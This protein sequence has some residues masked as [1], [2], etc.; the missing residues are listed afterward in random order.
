MASPAFSAHLL[1][2]KDFPPRPARH[3]RHRTP[4]AYRWRSGPGTVTVAAQD[5]NMQ[6]ADLLM[7]VWPPRGKCWKVGMGRSSLHEFHWVD[8]SNSSSGT[9]RWG[10]EISS[11]CLQSTSVP[12]L[13]F[14][15]V[16]RIQLLPS[17]SPHRPS[18]SH[19]TCGVDWVSLSP[20]GRPRCQRGVSLDWEHAVSSAVSILWPNPHPASTS[21]FRGSMARF[22]HDVLDRW[23]SI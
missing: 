1:Y 6:Q 10:V 7:S 8:W 3:G 12:S 17:S 20:Q 14:N 4:S 5:V 9:T 16:T 11:N 15:Q 21:G 22:P 19:R 2:S 13:P 18:T 23:G